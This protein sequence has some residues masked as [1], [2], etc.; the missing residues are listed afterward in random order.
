MK[1]NTTQILLILA[2]FILTPGTLSNNN[3]KID[4]SEIE[5]AYSQIVFFLNLIS[6]PFMVYFTYNFCRKKYEMFPGFLLSIVAL[7]LANLIELL[8]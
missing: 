1:N 4:A 5:A 2:L 6:L 8:S 3:L 7:S